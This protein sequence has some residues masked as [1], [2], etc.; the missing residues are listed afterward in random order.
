M[1]FETY[2]KKYF[3]DPLPE[4]RFRFKGILGTAVY[5]QDY[6]AALTF[7]ERV[8][9]APAYVEGELTHAWQL[10]NTWLTVFPAKDGSPANVEVMVYLK[11]AQE[12]DRLYAE[13]IAAGASGNPPI[14]TFMFVPVR[15]ATLQDPFG[16]QFSLVAEISE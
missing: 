8:F 5:Y 3:T 2:Q 12:V 9:G 4:P 13:M 16:G 6:A 1:D 15:I 10:G 11:D 7:F 14:D